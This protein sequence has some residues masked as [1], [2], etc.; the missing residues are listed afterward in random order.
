M[1]QIN[2]GIYGEVEKLDMVKIAKET[3]SKKRLARQGKTITNGTNKR[4]SLY[5]RKRKVNV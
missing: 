3:T 5:R 2:D 1:Q 4:R